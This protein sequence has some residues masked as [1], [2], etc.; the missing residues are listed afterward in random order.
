MEDIWEWANTMVMGGG[1][2]GMGW[3]N[4]YGGKLFGNGLAQWL[5]VEDI[6]E[7]A[8]TVVM[9]GGYLGMG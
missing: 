2:L 6:W 4:G 3:H 7:W 8:S 5:R 1:Y 9:G